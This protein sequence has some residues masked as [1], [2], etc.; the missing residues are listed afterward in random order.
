MW[1][2][3]VTFAVSRKRDLIGDND[4]GDSTPKRLLLRD[5]GRTEIMR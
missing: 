1:N 5:S 2:G 3:K 4:A